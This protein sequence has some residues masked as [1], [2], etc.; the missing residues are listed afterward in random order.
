MSAPVGQISQHDAL[1]NQPEAARRLRLSERTLERLR[2]TGDGPKFCKLGR[3]VLYLQSDLDAWVA[4][5]IVGSTSE[6]I[7]AV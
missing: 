5:R 2:S 1:L 3:R 7:G 6:V 4:S